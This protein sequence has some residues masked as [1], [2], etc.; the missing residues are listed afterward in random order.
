MPGKHSLTKLYPQSELSQQM[1]PQ[2]TTKQIPHQVPADSQ[3]NLFLP[4]SS[5]AGK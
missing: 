1:E 5:A 4:H 2:H 3:G